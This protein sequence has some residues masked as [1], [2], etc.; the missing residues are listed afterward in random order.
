MA[1][2]EAGFER[3]SGG[4]GALASVA[5]MVFVLLYTPCMVAVAAERQELG[6]KWTWVSVIGQLVLAWLVA[7][8]IFQGGLLLGLS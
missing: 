2:V 1:A 4:H 7:L 6:A 8:V 3:S 5:F